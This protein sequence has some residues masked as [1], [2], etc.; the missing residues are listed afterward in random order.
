MMAGLGPLLASLAA[1]DL[2][3]FTQRLKRNAVFYAFALV[4][5]LTGYVAAVAA[6]AVFLASV[7]GPAMALVAI[8]S[9]AFLLAIVMF[10]IVLI[11]NSSEQRRKREAA[12]ASG[13]RALMATAAITALPLLLKSRPLLVASILGGLGFLALRNKDGIG[14]TMSRHD[15]DSP[16][17][18]E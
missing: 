15:R 12:A 4:F 8:A 11:L 17:P 18:G 2:A 5:L 3:A 14:S 9:G 6:M 7:W 16:Q 1:V 13:S 10:T